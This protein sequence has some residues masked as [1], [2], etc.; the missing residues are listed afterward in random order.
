MSDIENVE[1]P[2]LAN[3]IEHLEAQKSKVLSDMTAMSENIK[4]L[5]NIHE[6]LKG[7]IAL[8]TSLLGSNGTEKEEED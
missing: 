3:Q 6:Q 2:S 5:N 7:A 8:A 1:M 4:Q